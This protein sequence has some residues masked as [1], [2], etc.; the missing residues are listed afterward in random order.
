MAKDKER[1]INPAQAQ[2]KLEKQ[3]A[4]KK[5]KAEIQTRRNEKLGRRNPERLQRQIDELKSL[6][7]SGQPL[8]PAER[9]ALAD[10]ERDVAAI[11]KARIA[12]G[13]KA[14]SFRR[15]QRQDRRHGNQSNDS[16]VLGKRRRNDHP[17][18][19]EDS[20]N[21]ETD[22][23]LRNIPMPRDTPPPIPPQHNRHRGS[24][25]NLEPIGAGRGGGE[26]NSH[27]LPPEPEVQEAK[28]VYESAPVVR[29][30]RQEAVSK[31]IPT[32]V[33]KKQ[34]AIKGQGRLV[35]PE[36]MD[37]LEK[38]GCGGGRISGNGG[39]LSSK[40]TGNA[41]PLESDAVDV[42]PGLLTA[43]DAKL[44]EGEASFERELKRVQIEEVEDEDF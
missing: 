33:R 5:G 21:S 18:W 12:L 35:E 27:A 32:A 30:L 9:K 34:E 40:T 17:R 24:N 19:R 1:S 2:R 20:D 37:R 38:E 28:A 13:D 42:A 26:W 11:R 41:N 25:A 22:E 15:E 39:V 7:S 36:E 44:L 4:V 14:P 8:K 16:S 3:K 23:S 10:L 43:P 29:N 6:E 31:F